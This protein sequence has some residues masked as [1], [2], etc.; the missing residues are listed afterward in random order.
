MKQDRKNQEGKSQK[1]TGI[2]KKKDIPKKPDPGID[3]DFAGYPHS[4][5]NEK[6]IRPVTKK[7]KAV[8]DTGNKDGEKRNYKITR[9]DLADD[10]SANAFE[11]TELTGDDE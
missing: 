9:D 3:R 6:V 10:G 5:A 8:A 11:R 2:L 7:E 1:N 4:G